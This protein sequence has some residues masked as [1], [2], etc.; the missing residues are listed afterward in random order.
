M[1]TYFHS[2]IDSKNDPFNTDYHIY[3]VSHSAPSILYKNFCPFYSRAKQKT[4]IFL[5][6]F[7]SKQLFRKKTKNSPFHVL[8]PHGKNCLFQAQRHYWVLSLIPTKQT[9]CINL[10]LNN[11]LYK[12]TLS[13]AYVASSVL[14]PSNSN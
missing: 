13:T 1:N 2:F 5:H 12:P 10:S 3:M 9:F 14:K 7:T 4:N 6:F 11:S 8:L